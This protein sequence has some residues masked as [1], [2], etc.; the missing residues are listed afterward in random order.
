MLYTYKAVAKTVSSF[1]KELS[2]ELFIF[3]EEVWEASIAPKIDTLTCN[4]A[5]LLAFRTHPIT[6]QPKNQVMDILNNM[7][8]LISLVP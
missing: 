5:K 6:I 8:E 7:K 1:K 3:K 2:A 4:D